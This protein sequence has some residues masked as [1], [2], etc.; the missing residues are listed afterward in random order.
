MDVPFIHDSL[1]ALLEGVPLT[2]QLASLSLAAGLVLAVVLAVMRV[3]G[4]VALNALASAYIF[5]FR[6]TP[7]L[8][9]IFLI[10]YG[11]GQFPWIQES[12]LWPFLRE[13]YYCA[14]L[15]L[16]LCTAAYSGEILRGG[17]LSVPHG[18]VEAAQA[19]GMP[20]LLRWRRIVLPLALRQALPAYG[21][22]VVAM[23]KSTSLASVITLMEV[24]GIAA[25]LIGETYRTLDVFVIAGAI[26]L[27][28][29]LLLTALI[30]RL[31]MALRPDSRPARHSP[32]QAAAV[33]K[34]EKRA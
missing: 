11:P 21:N 26:Y 1:A 7:L 12:I 23:V 29:N 25:R 33:A 10:Y 24:T 20:F 22:E 17:L 15:S 28:L 6:G 4:N 5:V 2:L 13:P 30:A 31:E 8:V 9:Q 19:C 18:Q 16:S 3:S 14:L 27:T 34:P 32:N